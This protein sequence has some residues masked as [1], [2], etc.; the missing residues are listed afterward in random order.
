MVSH[1]GPVYILRNE[2]G[3]KL[4]HDLAYT[5]ISMGRNMV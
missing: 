5:Y 4:S 1:Y 2:K 3:E